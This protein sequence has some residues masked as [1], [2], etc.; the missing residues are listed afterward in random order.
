MLNVYF[1]DREDEIYN[2]SMYFDH[3][4]LDKWF[5]DALSQKIIKSIDKATVIG[6]RTV[7][8][9]ALGV[10]PVTQL[11]GGTKTLLLLQNENK[12]FYNISTCG[13]NCAKWILRIADNS[14]KDVNVTLHHIMDFGNKEF[15]LR[16][17]NNDT[18]VH[19]MKELVTYAGS[20]L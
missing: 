13:D 2:T 20:F 3:T 19:N 7:E 15:E 5:Q 10:I 16:I 8:S 18:I 4:F 12:T 11:S 9:K 17:L 1:G 14:N 6:D